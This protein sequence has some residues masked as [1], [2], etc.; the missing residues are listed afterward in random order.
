[1]HFVHFLIVNMV[2]VNAFVSASIVC[3]YVMILYCLSD[4]L[5]FLNNFMIVVVVVRCCFGVV[6]CGGIICVRFFFNVYM[7]QSNSFVP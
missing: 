4:H 6:R 1:M 7:M 3:N 2:Q 5:C